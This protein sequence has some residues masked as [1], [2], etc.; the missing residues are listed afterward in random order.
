MSSI[1]RPLVFMIP[2]L[3]ASA[4]S[5]DA[6]FNYSGEGLRVEH[7][8]GATCSSPRDLIYLLDASDEAYMYMS[9]HAAFPLDADLFVSVTA[10]KPVRFTSPLFAVTTLEDNVTHQLPLP[11]FGGHA[12][13]DPTA[14][15]THGYPKGVSQYWTNLELTAIPKLRRFTIQFPPVEVGGKQVVLPLIHAERKTETYLTSLCLR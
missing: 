2:A 14:P 3:L 5:T 11:K 1:L 4:C 9:S 7:I 13:L 10:E 15:L 8:K 6:Y 12:Y